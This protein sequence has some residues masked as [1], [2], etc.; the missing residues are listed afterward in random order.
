MEFIVLNEQR[1]KLAAIETDNK[2][3]LERL[4]TIVTSKIDDRTHPLTAVHA[5]F[6]IDMLRTKKRIETQKITSENQRLLHRIRNCPP[7][8]HHAEWE[9]HARI[10]ERH[11]KSM[12]LYPEYYKKSEKS[13][14]GESSHAE[15]DS[16]T[17]RL[18]ATA[19]AA[20]CDT[21]DTPLS[22][23]TSLSSAPPLSSSPKLSCK[24]G[25]SYGQGNLLDMGISN[26]KICESFRLPPL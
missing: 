6:K 4:T 21:T 22:S 10:S 2:I 26:L 11:K 24:D 14:K 7:A 18:V 25:Q 23:R 19:M 9:E 17:R 20:M 16:A 1:R 12:S 15:Y 5:S 13:E 8:Y 3:L